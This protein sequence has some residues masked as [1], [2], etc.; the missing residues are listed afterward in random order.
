VGNNENTSDPYNNINNIEKN[1]IKNEEY[2]KK[3]EPF[4]NN[5]ENTIFT[6][7]IQYSLETQTNLMDL[8][9]KII[10][11]DVKVEEETIKNI[12][13]SFTH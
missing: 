8:T 10:K 4:Y 9:Y 6:D 2:R 13:V 12:S 3:L 1:F 5:I 7:E 11:E